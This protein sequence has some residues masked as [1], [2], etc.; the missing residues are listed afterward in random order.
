MTRARAF[1]IV[2]GD[3]RLLKTDQ[4]WN[5][6]IHYCFKE[7]GYRGISVFNGEEEEDTLTNVHRAFDLQP[8]VE[9]DS[10]TTG[11]RS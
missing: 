9:S 11:P 5:K 7:G 8:T 2:V 3:P 10:A 6:F 4:I 1:L